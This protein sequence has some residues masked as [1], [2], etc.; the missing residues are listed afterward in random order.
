M[1]LLILI[2]IEQFLETYSQFSSIETSKSKILNI[3]LIFKRLNSHTDK[4][5]GTLFCSRDYLFLMFYGIC[6]QT[7]TF[8][9]VNLCIVCQLK[10]VKSSSSCEFK[11]PYAIDLFTHV[12]NLL[13]DMRLLV[14]LRCISTVY[15]AL[16]SVFTFLSYKI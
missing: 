15:Y 6:Y 16:Y 4:A 2:L 9:V 11:A 7:G 12:Y 8:Q 3:Q 13:Q 1:L 5:M 14:L 10:F